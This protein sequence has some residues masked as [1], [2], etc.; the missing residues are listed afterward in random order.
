M[1]PRGGDFSSFSDSAFQ[2]GCGLLLFQYLISLLTITGMPLRCGPCCSD[3]KYVQRENRP[4][5]LRSLRATFLSVHR[6]PRKDFF[7]LQ[8]TCY[9]DG[10]DFNYKLIFAFVSYGENSSLSPRRRRGKSLITFSVRL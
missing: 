4:E 6:W 9:Q 2:S 1:L 10:Y 5:K 7:S 8:P 3:S